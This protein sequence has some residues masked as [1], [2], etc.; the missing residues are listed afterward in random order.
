MKH[1]LNDLSIEEKNSIREQHS[2]GMKVV[3]ENF[4]RLLNS[5]LGDSKPLVLVTEQSAKG[6][7]LSSYPADYALATKLLTEKIKKQDNNPLFI[8]NDVAMSLRKSLPTE[9]SIGSYPLIIYQLMLMQMKGGMLALVP[10][11]RG[12]ARFSLNDKPPL[13]DA[14]LL[15]GSDYRGTDYTPAAINNAYAASPLGISKLAQKFKLTPKGQ[16]YIAS[17]KKDINNTNKFIKQ[18]TGEALATYNALIS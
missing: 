3:T 11:F 15:L 4:S 13:E 8:G 1:I 16:E 12:D 7:K 14:P 18:L 2:G 5:K 9:N 10:V 17:L 6:L